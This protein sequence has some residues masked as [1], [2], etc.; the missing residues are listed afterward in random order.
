MKVESHDKTAKELL[1][2]S[3]YRIPR[4]QRGYAWRR[5]NIEEFWTDAIVDS[6]SDYFIG[7]MIVFPA[8]SDTLDI[9][10]GQQRLTTITLLLVAIR[11]SLRQ[12][13]LD[14][15]AEGLHRFIE[16]PDVDNHMRYVLKTE[17]SF[18]FLQERIQKWGDPDPGDIPIG[19]EER[20]LASAFDYFNEQLTSAVDAI[21]SDTTISDEQ[22]GERIRDKLQTI[23][24]Q[25]LGLQVILVKV[26]DEDDAYVIFETLNSRGQDLTVSDLVKNW[27]LRDLRPTNVE[28]DRPRDRWNSILES[29]EASDA[30]INANRFIHHSWLTRDSYVSEKKLFPAIKRQTRQK[31][32]KEDLLEQLVDDSKLYRAM[33]EPEF[34]KWKDNDR[35]LVSSLE[36]LIDFRITQANPFVLA[37]LKAR[38]RGMISL[39]QAKIALRAVECFHFMHTT[40]AGKSSSGGISQMY[41][42]HAR[43]LLASSDSNA[44]ARSIKDLCTKLR[45]KLPTRE[46]FTEEFILLRY[47]KQQTTQK[48]LVQYALRGQYMANSQGAVPD[49]AKLTIEHLAPEKPRSGRPMEGFERIGNLILVD[50]RTNDGL[51]NG[52]FLK[53]KPKLARAATDGQLWVDSWILQQSTWSKAKIEGRS[54]R[55]AAEA[56]D[57]I[58]RF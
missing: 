43:A 27:I 47:S 34:Y 46:E 20:E 21:T 23:R 14:D 48:R 9:V 16:R 50:E 41:A 33:Y 30:E 53:K 5:A 22:K 52:A 24:D 8:T 35:E 57:V 11:N 51:G 37:V 56:Y 26:D 44:R 29:F 19:P 54:R 55:M 38:K 32:A 13:G 40:I 15:L 39:R 18:P 2:E 7:S 49:F 1:H 10:D 25:V 3:Y 12:Q 6:V 42:G 17:S 31:S 58:W 36:A 45:Q 28:V 4:F